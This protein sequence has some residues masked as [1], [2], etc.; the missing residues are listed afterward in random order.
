MMKKI[1]RR[2]SVLGIGIA[3]TILM[4]VV[5]VMAEKTTITGS[6]IQSL[7]KRYVEKNAPWPRETTRVEFLQ[8]VPT[9]NL[10]G[11]NISGQVRSRA[12]ED[13]IGQTTF[14]VRFHDGERFVHEESVRIRL[15]VLMDVVVSSR[16]LGRDA[17]IGP[18]DVKVVRKWFDTLPVNRLSDIQDVLGKR[19]TS[20]V[21]PNTEIVRNMLRTIPLVKKGEMVRILLE[22]GPMSI[23]ATGLSQEEGGRGDIIKVQNM[24]SKKIIYARVM[25]NSLVRIDF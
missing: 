3:L 18:G 2:L 25:A 7:I 16:E 21:N 6:T 1:G 9:L 11:G 19:I 20:R 17:V 15:E 23:V 24:T 22:N 4:S 13:Y 10:E 8:E 12:N 14:S 5:P